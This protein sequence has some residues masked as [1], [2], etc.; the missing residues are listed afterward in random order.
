M[1]FGVVHSFLLVEGGFFYYPHFW[2][3]SQRG[4]ECMHICTISAFVLQ[5]SVM[6]HLHMLIFPVIVLFAPYFTT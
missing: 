3:L 1:S 2:T 5:L 6:P 4:A